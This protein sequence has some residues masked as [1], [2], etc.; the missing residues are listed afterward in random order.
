M[1]NPVAIGIA[2]LAVSAGGSLMQGAMAQRSANDQAR[3][4]GEQKAHEKALNATQEIRSRA[5][6]DAVIAQQASQITGAGFQADSPTALALARAAAAEKVFE[7]QSIRSF[8]Q[9]RDAEM[10]ATQRSLRA[11]G[12]QAMLGGVLGAAS[13]VIGGV[14]DIWPELF[15]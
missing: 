7:A 12:Q 1:C 4:V 13:S 5:Q 15:A 9:A 10:S 3:A 2:G 6:F 8:G 14:P 11:Q